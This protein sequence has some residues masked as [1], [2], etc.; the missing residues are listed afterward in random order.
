M[1]KGPIVILILVI[2]IFLISCQNNVPAGEQPL[3]TE[4]ALRMV[5]TGMEG[6]ELSFL[7]NY[8]PNLIY[9]QNELVAI[10]EVK[11]KG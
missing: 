4:A 11:N 6:V 9:D 3:E 7:P 8:P 5:Q 2:S 1:K 10:L